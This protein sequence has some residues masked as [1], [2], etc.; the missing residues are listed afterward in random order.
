MRCAP[1]WDPVEA[2][3]LTR[4]GIA[5]LVGAV[6]SETTG[7]LV[8]KAPGSRSTAVYL[9]AFAVYL[10]VMLPVGGAVTLH[11]LRR[12][13]VAVDGRSPVSVDSRRRL[14]HI[15]MREAAWTL[16]FWIGAAV[17]FGV[18][19]HLDRHNS[20]VVALRVSATIVLGGLTTA[21][22]TFLLVERAL[23]P[24]FR[25]VLANSPPE[26]IEAMS[27]RTRLLVSWALGSAIPLC[28]IALSFIGGGN[29]RTSELRVAVWA[30]ATVAIAAGAT[31]IVM[32]AR[33]VAEPLGALRAALMR[34]QR[35]DLDAEVAVDDA[36]EVGLLQAGFNK[37]VAGL[38]DRRNLEDLFGR[39]VGTDVAQLARAQG[40]HLGGERREASVVFVDLVGSTGLA[41]SRPA[42]EVVTLLNTFFATVVERIEH[43]G[44]WVNKFEGDAA[45]CVFGAPAA[46][47]DHATRALRAARTLRRDL[48][49][50]AL[51]HP[52]LDAG[53]GVSSGDVAAGNIG[54]AHRY[55]YTVIGDPVNEA[56]RLTE[57]AKA[58]AGGVLASEDAIVRASEDERRRWLVADELTLRG[59]VHPTLAYEPRTPV[60]TDLTSDHGYSR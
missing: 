28:I 27:I 26:G 35:D 12:G 5:N 1:R 39:H 31:M 46:Q 14:V 24:V 51:T 10:G 42:D 34:V 53:I 9:V 32:A 6:L 21:G 29:R 58:R 8:D 48:L 19:N 50:L 17:L 33:A 16:L 25:R 43:E 36:G 47:P 40:V 55:E 56:A 54:A 2:S 7:M 15:P 45:L 13:L 11:E 38:R 49:A 23:R 57:A 3:V 41:Q 20:G 4:I 18:L 59:R 52:A 30:L 60:P 22:V 44:G 37:M